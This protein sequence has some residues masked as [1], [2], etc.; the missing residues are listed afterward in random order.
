M[1]KQIKYLALYLLV[2][3]PFLCNKSGGTY[4]NIPGDFI[5]GGLLSVHFPNDDRCDRKIDRNGLQLVD[6]TIFAVSEVNF[7]LKEKGITLGLIAYD[8]CYNIN[9]S[10]EYSL[11]FAQQSFYTK[12]EETGNNNC[13]TETSRRVIGVIGPATSRETRYVA[14]LLALFK[15]PQISGTATSSALNDRQKYKYFKRTV[16]SDTYQAKGI[17][18]LL[19]ANGWEYVSVLYEDSS[20]GR[21]GFNDIKR[22]AQIDKICIGYE[23]Q[24]SDGMTDLEINE[25]ITHLRSRRNAKGKIVV[26]LFMLHQNAYRIIRQT[27]DMRIEGFIWIGSDGLTG[28]DPPVDLENIMEGAIGLSLGTSEYPGY[29]QYVNNQST[30]TNPNPWYSEFLLQFYPNCTEGNCGKI[31]NTGVPYIISVRD[32]VYTFGNAILNIHSDMCQNE[33]G[34]CEEVKE[35]LTGDILLEYLEKSKNPFNTSFHFVDDVE[36]PAKYS[37]L[38]YSRKGNSFQW[39][40]IGKFVG[41][42]LILDALQSQMTSACSVE[43]RLGYIKKIKDICCWDCTPCPAGSITNS[44]DPYSCTECLHGYTSNSDRNQCIQIPISY[45]SYG[46]LFSVVVL[47]LCVLGSGLCIIVFVVFVKKRHT[48][49]LKATGFET[50]MVL[51]SSVLLSYISPFILLHY[52]SPLSCALSRLLIGMSYTMAYSSVL[53]KLI[54]YKRAFD[55]KSGMKQKAAKGQHLPR[56]YMCTMM[57]ALFLSLGLSAMQLLAVIFWQISDTPE[58]TITYDLTSYPPSGHRMCKDSNNFN[59]FVLLFWPFMLMIACLVLAIKTRKLPNGMNDSREIMYCSFTSFIIWLAFVPLYAFSTT[60]AARVISLCVSLFIHATVFLSCLFLT[61][62]YIVVFRPEKNNKERVMRSTTAKKNHNTSS[63]T[64]AITP[65]KTQTT[66]SGAHQSN[67]LQTTS[68][69]QVLHI[70]YNS[71]I[72]NSKMESE[73]ILQKIKYG[74]PP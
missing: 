18:K 5:L 43:C 19:R 70:S 24:T 11:E 64:S 51:L 25:V 20:Y 33:T 55:V 74:N 65:S 61:K 48:P 56:P 9:P 35:K 23:K 28:L 13:T 62:I 6:A 63:G 22:F 31:N 45:F 12:H 67:D 8:T 73:V 42:E 46:N 54:V 60:I 15:I 57:T 66:S 1:A 32:A 40:E 16:P 17:V 68:K 29:F 58:H 49:L 2:V 10:L 44:S 36:G 47:I 7:Y 30:E 14:S 26:V 41:E 72:E 39:N 53:S 69:E 59:Y 38:Q 4:L 52:P 37:I 34:V 71:I 27:H 3:W 21:Y 50:S